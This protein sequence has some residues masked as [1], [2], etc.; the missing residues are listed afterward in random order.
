M[1]NTMA[2]T[3]QRLRLLVDEKRMDNKKISLGLKLVILFGDSLLRQTLSS[4]NPSL[5]LI[6]N[7]SKMYKTQF[8]SIHRL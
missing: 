4:T 6:S 8:Q 1:K 5:Y 2:T 7:F 3:Y